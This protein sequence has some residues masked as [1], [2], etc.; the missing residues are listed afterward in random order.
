[1]RTFRIFNK[2]RVK[3]PRDLKLY[4]AIINYFYDELLYLY[5]YFLIF[6]IVRV[7]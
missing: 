2:Q 5:S 7:L 3:T 1:M 4:I 6:F